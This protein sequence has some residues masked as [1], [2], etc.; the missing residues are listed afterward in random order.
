MELVLL[1]VLDR[2]HEPRV[3]MRPRLGDRVVRPKLRRGRLGNRLEKLV[4]KRGVLRVHSS[5]LL[6]FTNEQL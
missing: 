4:E 1:I 6:S 5:H 2:A 3:P